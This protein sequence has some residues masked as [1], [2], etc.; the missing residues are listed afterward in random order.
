MGQ[1][2]LCR[3]EQAEE[4]PGSSSVDKLTARPLPCVFQKSCKS[5]RLSSWSMCMQVQLWIDGARPE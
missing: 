1:G 2:S 4:G 3:E 5:W